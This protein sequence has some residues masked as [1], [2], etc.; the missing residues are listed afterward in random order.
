G[1]VGSGKT[2]VAFHALLRAVESGWQGVMMAP[3]ELLAEQHFQNFTAM[4]GRL[5]LPVALIT[6]TV[7]GADRSR[8]LRALERGDIRIAFG[9]HALFQDDVRIVKLG[10]AVIDEQHRFGVFDRARLIARGSEA[11]VLLMTAT[12]IPRSL[13]LTLLRNLDISRLDEL[14]PGRTPVT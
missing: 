6:G 4:C 12:P 10:L 9:T 14:P 7:F 2:L 11:N 5:G 13:A 8:L 3:T 1:D